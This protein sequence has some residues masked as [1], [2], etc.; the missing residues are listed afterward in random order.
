V[1]TTP[2]GSLNPTDANGNHFSF[3]PS[4]QTLDYTGNAALTRTSTGLSYNNQAGNPVNVSIAT[5]SYPL[6]TYFQCP[7]IAEWGSFSPQPLP[8]KI[9]MPDGSY[10]RITYEAT[11]N[12]PNSRT[13]RI[14]S[15]TLPTGG[16][17]TYTYNGP[18]NGINCSDGSTSGFTRQTSDGTWTYTHSFNSTTNQW[19]TVITAPSG[20]S[21]TY[22]FTSYPS[23]YEVSRTY[24]ESNGA[25]TATIVTCYNGNTVMSSCASQSRLSNLPAPTEVTAFTQL[26]NTSGQVSEI[27]TTYNSVSLPTSIKKYNYG[28]GAPGP[29]LETTTI[30][31]G[32]Y[33]GSGCTV[34][35]NNIVTKPCSVKVVDGPSGNTKSLTYYSYD[36]TTPVALSGTT[37]HQQ[38]SGSRGNLEKVQRATS[39][40]K[41]LVTKATH[42]DTGAIQTSFDVNGAMTTYNYSSPTTTCGNR[43]PDSVSLPLGQTKSFTWDCNGGVPTSGIDVN[44][45]PASQTNSDP[46]WRLTSVTDQTNATTSFSY[47]ATTTESILPVTTGASVDILSTV[48]GLGR[49][50]IKQIR[51]QPQPY[52]NFDTVSSS[53]D[54]NG[55]PYS[56]SLPC[57]M[58]ASVPCPA[59]TI[60]QTYDAANRPLTFTDGDGGTISLTYPLNDV[61]RVI[62]PPP[63]G[64][65]NKSRQLEYDGLQRL[66]SVCEILSSGGSSCGQ[67]S[68]ASGYKTSY[69]YTTPATGGTTMVA[70]Q[71]TQSRTYVRDPLGRLISETNPEWGPG[72]ATYTY[73]SD[74]SGTCPGTYNGDLVKR[75]DNASNVTCYTY[76]ALHRKLSSTYTGQNPTMNRYFVYDSASVNGVAMTNAVGR[77]AEGYTA[78]CATCTKLTDEGFSYDKRGELS[79]SY[80]STPNSGGYYSV[81]VTYWPNGQPK[82]VGPFL[83]EAQVSITADGE[84]RPFAING[85][86]SNILYNYAGQPT[87]LM[88]SCAA[89]CYPIAYQYDPN[90]LRMTQYS[91]AG[92]NGTLSGTLTWNPNG[93]LGQLVVA[94]PVNSADVQTCT[95]SA[96]DLARLASVSC[97]SGA[98]WG[99]QF[100]YDPFGNITKTVPSNAT[101]VSW[102]PGYS[103]ST[104]RYL[105]GGT[106]YDADGN[107]LNDNFNTYTWDAEGKQLSTNYGGEETFGF[108]YDALGHMVELAVNGTY[109]RSYMSLGKFRFSATGQTAG[110]SETPLPGGSIASQ[111]GGDTGIQIA[112]WLG[113]IRGNS[114]YTG[115]IVN[116]TGARAPF[117]EG[118]AGVPP[119]AFTGQDGDGNRSNPIYWFPER[120]YVSTQGRW[121]SSDPAGFGAVDPSNPQTW[122]RYGYVANNPLTLTDPTGT[123]TGGGCPPPQTNACPL[124]FTGCGSNNFPCL[125]CGLS[126][127]DGLNVNWIWGSEEDDVYALLTVI[128]IN[129]RTPNNI[130]CS[131]VL[132]NGRTVGNYVS[133]LSNSLNQQGQVPMVSTPYGPAPNPSLPSPI[134]VASQVYSGLNFKIMF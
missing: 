31:Y 123:C 80:E 133:Q 4:Q 70:T 15:I 12:N 68:P 9:T 73:D 129:N 121:I 5:T 17:E 87:Q 44:G 122:N 76:D 6:A 34:L 97:N 52:A 86:A 106:S 99:Q 63:T 101:G 20:Q 37:Q 54:T 77:L 79:A 89:N 8:T 128:A 110:Y 7:G 1:L 112:D 90:T 84:G 78:T 119:E 100:T 116:N 56:N 64:E 69:S 95:Y 32:S 30:A 11:P 75:V 58:T 120:Q 127:W 2:A 111:N 103:S 14:A 16:T 109:T 21:L 126:S 108:T 13:G 102:I 39:N 131:T 91:F 67:N 51:Q 98:T 33:N 85:S 10:Y 92:S 3:T 107:V 42:Y 83:N 47:T 50:E 113:T 132:P 74:P 94:D 125:I 36:L 19:Q 28:G 124:V 49:P 55:R 88:V 27:D 104:N 25:V 81:P 38:V 96:D 61:L 24:A 134:S 57:G 43:Y 59:S 117:G 18:N 71:S 66:I 130:T 118:Y 35:G 48:D 62:G 40:S 105:L 93:S 72:T 46:Y 29:L 41:F 60:S 45:N 22:L 53:Y 115:G 82:T 23:E 114:N 26:P 65:H